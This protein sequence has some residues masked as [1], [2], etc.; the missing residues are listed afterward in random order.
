MATTDIGRAVPLLRGEYD[1]AQTYELNDIV[2]LNGSLYW[3]Y[4]H[5][6]T[7]NVAPQATSTWKIVLSL[8]DA[9]AYIARAES[10]AE[11]AESAKDDAVTA[12]TAAETASAT[13]TGASEA[14]TAAKD[15]AVTAR[16]AAQTA[17]TG[18][19]EA[20]NAAV[21]AKEAAQ[22]AASSAG[23][24]ATNASNSAG[25]AEYYAENAETA[26]ET[27]TTKASE[28][29][30]SATTASSAA[31]TA[32]EAKNT[33]VSSASTA[34]TK[35]G[36]AST[37]AT[38][39]ASSAAA[40]Q[41]VKDSIPEDY[42]ALSE[43]VSELKTQI[44][45]S[46]AEI[47][48]EIDD[49]FPLEFENGT[50]RS[51]TVGSTLEKYYGGG[52]DKM[53]KVVKSTVFNAPCD[54]V[55]T[56]KTGYKL[57]VFTA[58]NGV[59]TIISG[60][61][62]SYS[63]T[64]G[65]Q[66]GILLR[67]ESGSDDISALSVDQI[68]DIEYA[69]KIDDIENELNSVV[70][71]MKGTVSINFETATTKVGYINN[72]NKWV[73]GGYSYFIPCTDDALSL[74]VKANAEYMAEISFLTTDTITANAVPDYCVG[75][76]QTAVPAGET[77]SL[78]IPEDCAYI[79][80][81]KR[82]TSQID[83]TPESASIDVLLPVPAIDNTLMKSG[84]AADAKVTGD[85]IKAVNA[86]IAPVSLDYTYGS[87]NTYV[88]YQDGT[89][90]TGR[91]GFVATGYIDITGI[92]NIAYTQC[93][94]G[95]TAPQHGMAFY[96]ENKEYIS[97][98]RSA[99][100]TGIGTTIKKAAVP[101]GAVYARF[102][103]WSAERR[104]Q[105]GFENFKVYDSD[106]YSETLMGRVEELELHPG[107]PSALVADVPQNEGVQNAI[108]TARQFTDIKWTPLADVPGLYL[109]ISVTPSVRS[110]KS[111]KKGCRQTG[112][113][114]DS[115]IGFK[116]QAG[117]SAIFDTFATAL[118]NPNSVMYT[119]DRYDADSRPKQAAYYGISCSKM[120]QSCWD[121]PAIVDSSQIS[122]LPGITLIAEP[123]QYSLE[124]IQLGDGVL[125]PQVHCTIVT[126]IFRDSKGAAK[127][128][129]I[130]E[131]T[132]VLGGRCIRRT[133]S[134]SEFY[135]YF[136]TYGLYRYEHIDKVRYKK[137]RYIDLDDGITAPYDIPIGIR[138]GSYVNVS[139]NATLK[140]DVDSTK[141]VTLHDVVGGT[142]NTSPITGDEINLP[143]G[144]TG[145]HEVYP[146]DAGGNRG[147]SSYYFVPQY[148]A[149]A[150]VDGGNVTVTWTSNA[151]VIALVFTK[152]NPTTNTHFV[153]IFEDTG[154]FT[155]EIPSGDTK[156]YL[157]YESEYGQYTGSTMLLV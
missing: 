116:Y 132:T 133:F 121:T 53:R 95:V 22:S 78:D 35:A 109:D 57:N 100:A 145:Y 34:T 60:V 17:E 13:A 87:E 74:T 7:T 123:G 77:V 21:S 63:L 72:S 107:A 154:T 55:I 70:D 47:Y 2:S 75:T 25:T 43:D 102:T 67:S 82:P 59:I 149:S 97:G 86:V 66:Y 136:A 62:D 12:K 125:N 114:Y 1:P 146:E 104:E 50:Y 80:I 120:V 81:R 40:A 144:T 76:T 151:P 44:K 8:T 9:E 103:W 38:S 108:L 126:G 157:I 26:A 94:V 42:S 140:A 41:A 98:I 20:K 27:A 18:A 155:A 83:P 85:R 135:S 31:T 90:L 93:V 156:C 48:G 96:N 16:N 10:A 37:S 92:Q 153:R 148:S 99:V 56:A 130:S 61:V 65:N 110:Y 69:S 71:N 111:H 33:A 68:I 106:Q 36:E 128:I 91:T 119:V 147:N 143:T 89:I 131:S 6:V 127:A 115:G 28:A 150:S 73:N 58:I 54:V 5:E 124:D 51:I 3:H 138:E 88:K 46:D 64:A 113:T 45:L 32:T 118:L 142:D 49:T 29:S 134:E 139:K 137:A 117:K 24:S 19:V 105:Y 101:E 30:A 15:D 79:C 39:A 4:S 141:W 14:A 11:E 152:D 23:T 84:D 129:E 52:Y 122:R 112:I